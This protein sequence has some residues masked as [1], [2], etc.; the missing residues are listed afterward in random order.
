MTRPAPRRRGGVPLG[1][2]ERAGQAPRRHPDE[3]EYADAASADGS[4]SGSDRQ[5]QTRGPVTDE[6]DRNLL[7]GL[8]YRL[9]PA[10]AERMML[11]AGGR[12]LSADACQVSAGLAR[13]PHSKP[14]CCSSCSDDVLAPA[15]HGYSPRVSHM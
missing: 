9:L 4:A 15:L 3:E 5:Q 7:D 10:V 1:Y 13:I 14:L 8:L 6:G 11:G 12:R 2:R